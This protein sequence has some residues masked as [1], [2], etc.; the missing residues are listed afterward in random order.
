MIISPTTLLLTFILFTGV[1]LIGCNQENPVSFEES[2]ERIPSL[3]PISGGQNA[4]LSARSNRSVS[5]FTFEVG[6][7]SENP[8]ISGGN[9]EG[10]CAVYNAPIKTDGTQ[11]TGVKL[12]ST[13]SDRNKW[14]KVNYLLNNSEYHTGLDNVTYK[15]IQ[16][17]IWALLDFPAFDL[18]NLSAQNLPS[19]FINNGEPAF[20]VALVKA[21][22]SYS[23]E[24]GSDFTL[25]LNNR[26]AVYAETEN[27]VQNVIIVV[28]PNNN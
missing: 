18:N 11:Y 21:I 26:Y 17:A 7:I 28:E 19:S 15:E 24:K 9:F 6:N 12:Y 14:Q 8:H 20:D 10:W 25:G 23:V 16:V 1:L 4:T 27:G 2:S 22:V 5:Y 13:T 3:V